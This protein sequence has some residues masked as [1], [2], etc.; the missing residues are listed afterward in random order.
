MRM[1]RPRDRKPSVPPR[2]LQARDLECRLPLPEANGSGQPYSRPTRSDESKNKDPN[3]HPG[4]NIARP[5]QQQAQRCRFGPFL[6]NRSCARHRAR[7]ADGRRAGR[8]SP[9]QSSMVATASRRIPRSVRPGTKGKS[10]ASRSG[11][12]SA[13]PK[14]E[15]PPAMS[16]SES[17]SM[18]MVA[19]IE[20]SPEQHPRPRRDWPYHPPQSETGRYSPGDPSIARH[21]PVPR[22]NPLDRGV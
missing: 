2:R 20:P 16:H 6:G 13:V 15:S 22:K 12:I 19:L 9:K 14:S 8:P 17:K 18:N 1:P 11:A 5:N 3:G 7:I 4:S 21:R 10:S